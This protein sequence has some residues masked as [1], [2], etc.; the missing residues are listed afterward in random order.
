MFGEVPVYEYEGEEPTAPDLGNNIKAMFNMDIGG[1]INKYR[2]QFI[3]SLEQLE[4]AQADDVCRSIGA[5]LS[6]TEGGKRKEQAKL[7]VTLED[8]RNKYL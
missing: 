3:N 1:G 5:Y 4:P 2:K 6:F 7:P 8:F